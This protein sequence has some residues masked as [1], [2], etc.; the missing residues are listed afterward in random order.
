MWQ[1]IRKSRD[2]RTSATRRIMAERYTAACT[3]IMHLIEDHAE[4]AGIPVRFAAAK[5]AEGDHLILDQLGLDENEKETLEH[6]II[7]DGSRARGSTVPQPLR[8]CGLPLSKKI[9]S[10]T[11]VKPH[12]SKRASAQRAHGPNP[13]RKVH[14]DPVLHRRSWRLS[15]LTFNVIRRRINTSGARHQL[16]DGRGGSPLYRME[17]Q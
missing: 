5:L 12:E 17:R 6:I 11:V 4:K 1:S 15:F 3:G 2:G 10:K 14:G 8:I 16:S 13:H 7:T 9:C